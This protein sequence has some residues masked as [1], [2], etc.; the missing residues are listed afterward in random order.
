MTRTFEP[1]S[2]CFL[3]NNMLTAAKNKQTTATYNNAVYELMFGM[4]SVRIKNSRFMENQPTS[5]KFLN[6]N[7]QAR[8]SP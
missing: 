7:V 4:N 1:M 3:R 5:F 8:M 6:S 2:E